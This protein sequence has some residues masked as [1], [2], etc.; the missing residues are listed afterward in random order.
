MIKNKF[1]T[2]L[3]KKDEVI[4]VNYTYSIVREELRKSWFKKSI[5][6]KDLYTIDIFVKNR[7]DKPIHS[8][9]FYDKNEAD[10]YYNKIKGFLNDSSNLNYLEISYD[11]KQS[12]C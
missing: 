2:I 8:A 9:K 10:R 4:G 6:E 11:N 1:R 12:Y 5:T 7:I 3:L